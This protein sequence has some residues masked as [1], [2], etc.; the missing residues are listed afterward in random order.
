MLGR[1]LVEVKDFEKGT[2]V[3]KDFESEFF[4]A[5]CII[6]ENSE[7]INRF[8]NFKEQYSLRFLYGEIE[9]AK[10]ILDSI[11]AEFGQSLWLIKNKLSFYQETIGL[12]KNKS[13]TN[14][15]KKHLKNGSLAKYIIHWL[16]IRNENNVSIHKFNSQIESTISKLNKDDFKNWQGVNV[17]YKF[18]SKRLIK[19]IHKLNKKILTLTF[20]KSHRYP[21]LNIVQFLAPISSY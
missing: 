13:Y 19:K 21:N 8:L 20:Y 4:W 7:K 11:E 10:K 17:Y 16:S 9:E 2:L 12:E 6:Q 3:F 15:L 1:D 18:C 14:S 5:K